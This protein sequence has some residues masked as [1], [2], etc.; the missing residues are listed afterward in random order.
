MSLCESGPNEKPDVSHAGLRL[1][2]LQSWSS[3]ASLPVAWRP[4]APE[5]RHSIVVTTDIH[6]RKYGGRKLRKMI[7]ESIFPQTIAKF[8]KGIRAQPEEMCRSLGRRTSDV[9]HQGVGVR[10]G[11]FARRWKLP[12][13]PLMACGP[14]STS[15]NARITARNFSR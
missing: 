6:K 10:Q 11:L 8:I 14:D 12:S 7:H 15:W 1:R 5:Y 9:R 3:G 4:E 13:I 2:R